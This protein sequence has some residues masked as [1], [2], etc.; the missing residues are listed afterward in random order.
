MSIIAGGPGTGKTHTVARILAAAHR[1][2]EDRSKVLRVALA[3]PT[4]KAAARMTEAVEAR[5]PRWS[6]EARH[7]RRCG[8]TLAA[9]D[10]DHHPPAAGWQPGPRSATTARIRFLHDLVIIDETSMVSLPLMA[11]LLDA[12]RPEARLVLVGDPFQLASIE[13]G[14]VMADMVGPVGST[15]AG[16][17]RAVRHWPDGSPCSGAGH[18]FDDGSAIAALA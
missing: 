10:A 13:A 2:A 6:A 4:G 1:L 12:V 15:R 16:R 11:R 8:R 3:A 9:I 18:R 14:T 7:R 5:S 17:P